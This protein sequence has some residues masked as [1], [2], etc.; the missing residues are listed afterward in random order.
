MASISA[1]NVSPIPPRE[2][3]ISKGLAFL[4]NGSISSRLV[5]EKVAHLEKQGLTSPEIMETLHRL[6]VSS[7]SS[8]PGS[9]IWNSLIAAAMVGV[10]YAAYELSTGEEEY[11]IPV[12]IEGMVDGEN[13]DTSSVENDVNGNLLASTMDYSNTTHLQDDES[14]TF[15]LDGESKLRSDVSDSDLVNMGINSSS[16]LG[17]LGA[18]TSTLATDLMV[19]KLQEKAAELSKAVDEAV[20]QLGSNDAPE[21]SIELATIQKR[22]LKD[23]QVIKDRLEIYAVDTDNDPNAIL[24]TKKITEYFSVDKNKPKRQRK[25]YKHHLKEMGNVINSVLNDTIQKDELNKACSTIIMYVNNIIN[26]PTIP[27]YHKISTSNATFKASLMPLEGHNKLLESIGFTKTGN[28]FEW[29]T[30]SASSTAATNPDENMLPATLSQV[31]DSPERKNGTS[32]TTTNATGA[33]ATGFSAMSTEERT[34]IL[35]ESIVMLKAKQQ[36]AV[37]A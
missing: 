17:Q 21:W 4:T 1:V 8:V 12:S 30:G 10:G 37:V 15:F 31:Y 9:W 7:G 22:M 35:Q 13:I 5:S 6:Q 19:E 3:L 36:N 29:A 14:D 25:I 24:S 16:N 33:I 2:D 27:R 23:L 20:K 26:N 34:N 11:P 18:I 28:Y 32:T